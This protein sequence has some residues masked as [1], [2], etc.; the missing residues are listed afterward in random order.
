MTLQAFMAYY[1]VENERRAV[2]LTPSEGNLVVEKIGGEEVFAEGEQRK[3]PYYK[4]C[5]SQPSNPTA[6]FAKFLDEAIKVGKLK[7]GEILPKLIHP[8]I[9]SAYAW[10]FGLEKNV[11]IALEAKQL[12]IGRH[13]AEGIPL[14]ANP[15]TY[16]KK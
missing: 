11:M 16:E 3:M 8:E 7:V 6:T 9:M 14:N 13:L 4:D 10:T 15:L 12:Q 1:R 5:F 2:I